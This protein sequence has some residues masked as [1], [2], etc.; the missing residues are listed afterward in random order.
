MSTLLK[1]FSEVIGDSVKSFK[2]T[3][4]VL[5]ISI[6]GLEK[7]F[8]YLLKRILNLTLKASFLCLLLNKIL[9]TSLFSL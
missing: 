5:F 6:I 3:Y 8:M 7:R 4:I 2:T 9:Y 1:F